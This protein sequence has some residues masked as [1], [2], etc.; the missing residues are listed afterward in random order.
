MTTCVE[1]ITDLPR[2]ARRLAVAAVALLAGAAGAC[3]SDGTGPDDGGVVTG[4]LQFVR[5]DPTA[6]S[7]VAT[8]ASSCASRYR[9]RHSTAVPTAA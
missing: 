6:P 8:T 3:S 2:R 9:R 5:P 1:A 4:E 7:L